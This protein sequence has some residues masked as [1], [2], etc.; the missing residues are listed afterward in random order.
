MALIISSTMMQCDGKNFSRRKTCYKCNK[1][2]SIN[3][4]II[5]VVKQRSVALPSAFDASL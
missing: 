2:K 1:D 5:P 3:S 4:K